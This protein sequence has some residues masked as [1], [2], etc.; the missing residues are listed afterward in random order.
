MAN[1]IIPQVLVFQDFTVQSSAAANPLSAF[2]TGGHAQLVRYQE[3]QERA[4]GLL[5]SYIR[6]SETSYEWPNRAPGGVIDKNFTKVFIQ[7]AL[8]QYYTKSAGIG[9]PISVVSGSTSVRAD[10]INFATNGVYARDAAFYGRDVRPGDIIKVRGIPSGG[11]NP[12]TLW[13]SVQTLIADQ[14]AAV[15]GSPILDSSNAVTQSAAAT[16]SQTSGVENCVTATVD[17]SGYNGLAAGRTSE[18]YLVTVL[19]SSTGGDLTT[20]RLRVV[21]ASGTDNQALVTPAAAGSPTTIGTRG[22]TVTFDFD[23]TAACSL[24]AD[25]ANV[26]PDDL[27]VG[28]QFTVEVAQAFTAT[29]ATAAGTYSST[30]NTTYLVEVT[31]GGLFGSA[32]EI[33]VS[34][35]NG[36]DLSG[37]HIVSGTGS[38][39]AIGTK[40]VTIEFAGSAG[41]N[42]GDRFYIP[43]QGISSGPI[44]TLGLSQSLNA[45]FAAGDE[46]SIELYIRKPNLEIA[47]VTASGLQSNWEQSAT[48]ITLKAGLVA[49][50]E[51]WLDG[52]TPLPLPIFS[53]QELGFGVAY[54]EY[55]AWLS[56]LSFKINGISDVS[57]LGDISGPLTPD[58]PLKWAVFKALS[59]SNGT[60][61][62]YTAVADPDD[63]DSWVDVLDASLS[64]DDVY[65]MVP[66][67]RNQDVLNLF[68]AHVNSVSS[69][70]LGL[71]RVAWVNLQAIPEIPLVSS[72]SDVPGYSSATTTDGQPALAVFEDDPNTSGIQY[73]LCRVPS[74]NSNFITNKVRPGDIVRAL[75]AGDI[76]GNQVYSEFV[77]DAILSEDRLR[78]KAGP[79][80]PQPIPSKI[81]IWRNLSAA[82]EAVEIAKVAKSYNNPRVR[83]TWPDRIESAGTVQEGY[84]LNAALAGLASGVLPHQGLTNV[85]VSGFSSTN[86]TNSKFNRTQLNTMAESGVWIVRQDDFTGEIVTR[87]ALTT[88]DYADINRREEMITRNVDSISYR[89][90]DFFAPFIGSSNVTP[91]MQ[92]TIRTGLG[93]LISNLVNANSTIRLGGQLISAEVVSLAVSSVFRDRYVAVIT[94]EV[95]YALNNI[96]LRLVV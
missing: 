51:S 24:S 94:L 30:E 13:T 31:K 95:P 46:V 16:V 43:V 41:L 3:D 93:E 10:N 65:N 64:R 70:D 67:T 38:A 63:L 26:S 8:L 68:E 55:R 4:S 25:N 17:G 59:N 96:E 7:N 29:T 34:T 33:L 61:V 5:G 1:Y 84:H 18:T 80:L 88:G 72:G 21:S 81:E 45:D 9:Q 39:V 47:K 90:K 62:L 69:A 58:N 77:V 23:S 79:A 49:F 14:I 66:L 40:G 60:Q 36:I 28:Q 92:A 32:P 82:E 52:S 78:L 89:F 27:I 57:A 37:P 75:Y 22:L 91:V 44:R 42:K 85:T 86:R 71:W 6:E 50:D 56:D 15:I 53:A 11:S 12:V 2:I 54:V 35:S 87:H 19:D 76:F 73:T 20:A 74:A 83:A 48:E